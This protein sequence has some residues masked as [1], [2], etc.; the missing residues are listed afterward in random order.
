MRDIDKAVEHLHILK[1]FFEKKRDVFDGNPSADL[2]V[3]GKSVRDMNRAL[4]SDFIEELEA[5]LALL[6]EGV[7][8]PIESTG[9]M[10]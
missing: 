6:E 3:D 8:R 9:L 4:W 7:V 5:A 10:A 2:E 1:A